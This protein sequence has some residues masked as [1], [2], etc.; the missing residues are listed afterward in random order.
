MAFPSL[1]GTI[2]NVNS[3]AI[4]GIYVND[5]TSSKY[6]T[7]GDI[8]EPKLHIEEFTSPNQLGH[9]RTN[10]AYNITASV[11]MN[12]CSVTEIE[13]LDSLCNGTNS[14]L[15]KLADATTVTTSAAYAGWV[16]F[17]AAQVNVRVV[18]IGASG[19]SEDTRRI[20]L[21]WHGT[22]AKSDANEI[23][24]LTPTLETANFASTADSATAVFYAIG[25]YTAATDGG[26]SKPANI[27]SCGTSSVKLDITGGSGVT[28]APVNNI[29]LAIE[30]LS[31]ED[32][33]LRPITQGWNIAFAFDQMS[34]LNADLLLLGN[35]TVDTAKA[36]VTMLDG[37]VFTFDNQTGIQAGFDVQ[38]DFE[39]SR[40]IRWTLNGKILKTSLDGVVA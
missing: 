6:Q 26:A 22:V 23:A 4:L 20:E 19:T 5:T 32:D 40:S 31:T 29:D 18:R 8:S 1:A 28:I 10:K 7:L 33:I 13:L 17:T 38:G 11:R 30:S 34:T 2:A 39:K 27:L 36:I 37:M 24:M 12:Q 15:F 35:A 9:N 14:W 16:K 25:T 21:E 3:S